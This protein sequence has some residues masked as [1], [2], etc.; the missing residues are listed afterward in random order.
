MNRKTKF[1]SAAGVLAIA[2]YLAR[3]AREKSLAELRKTNSLAADE[4]GFRPAHR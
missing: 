2:A 4:G 1:M 3:T